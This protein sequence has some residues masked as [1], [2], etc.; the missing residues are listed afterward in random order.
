MG[1]FSREPDWA[2]IPIAPDERWGKRADPHPALADVAR[3]I[4]ARSNRDEDRVDMVR[5]LTGILNVFSAQATRYLATGNVRNAEANLD[6]VLGR[7]DLTADM[8]WDFLTH[9][10]AT[11]IA[12]H[13]QLIADL[14]DDEFLDG[15][16]SAV[17]EGSFDL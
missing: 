15:M 13:N 2:T 7:Y 3:T 4:V 9:F 6:K 17:S 10:E 14:T 8:P 12:A 16:A 11:G 5:L 1:L